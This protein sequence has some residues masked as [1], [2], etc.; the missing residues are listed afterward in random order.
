MEDNNK[1][2]LI[3][4]VI[5][6]IRLSYKTDKDSFYMF[7]LEV[8]TLIKAYDTDYEIVPIIVSEELINYKEMQINKKIMV[9]GLFRTIFS[10][11]SEE[12]KMI[13]SIIAKKIILEEEF[14]VKAKKDINLEQFNKAILIGNICRTPIY[15]KTPF[16]REYTD[17]MVEVKTDGKNSDFALV[18]IWGIDARIC[19]ELKKETKVKVIGKI[20]I[21]K[22][23]KQYKDGTSKVKYRYIVVS[24][25][26]EV[27]NYDKNEIKDKNRTY[28]K[29]NI[30]SGEKQKNFS[31]RLDVGKL[32]LNLDNE[33]EVIVGERI[34]HLAQ[35]E[36]EVLK[37][38][39]T[40][41][42]Q[43]ISR[44]QL[45]ENVLGYEYY[46]DTRIVDVIIRRIR[47]KIEDDIRNPKIL[48]GKDGYYIK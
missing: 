9:E 29:E 41:Q 2:V 6:K 39:L 23:E 42:G 47:E 3:G 45:L 22:Y 37:Y 28:Q 1:I 17:M 32:S 24:S 20:R 16:G 43:I 30:T 33:Y 26:I 15:K 12:P 7:D 27:L 13:P 11:E 4:K 10:S 14:I 46:R 21:T 25:K 36:F 5:S 40:R 18:Q 19:R 35:K 8:P 34:E 31:K 44:E 38:L 48:L